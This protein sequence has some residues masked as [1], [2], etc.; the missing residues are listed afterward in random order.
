[1]AKSKIKRARGPRVVVRLP[2]PAEHR[3]RLFRNG[4]SQAVRIP[5]DLRF[6]DREVVMYR[7]GDRLIIEPDISRGWKRFAELFLAGGAP[8]RTFP[9]RDQPDHQEREGL[10]R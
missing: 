3:A 8:D 2:Q 5:K 6:R 10:W 1:M 9:P 7:E 4:G